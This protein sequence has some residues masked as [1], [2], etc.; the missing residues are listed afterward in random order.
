MRRSADAARQQARYDSRACFGCRMISPIGFKACLLADEISLYLAESP[1]PHHLK[2]RAV[3]PRPTP[4]WALRRAKRVAALRRFRRR[5]RRDGSRSIARRLIASSCYC[6]QHYYSDAVTRMPRRHYAQRRAARGGRVP[7]EFLCRRSITRVIR[8][9]ARRRACEFHAMASQLSRFDGMNSR[10]CH[11]RSAGRCLAPDCAMP[12]YCWIN[13]FNSHY[14]SRHFMMMASHF[15]RWRGC[16][17]WRNDATGGFA[18]SRQIS[19]A[20]LAE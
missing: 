5:G 17:L 11:G 15:D 4:P 14:A 8:L 6:R 13:G 7:V 2:C 9:I 1:S 10:A 18:I 20:R 12:R 19:N 16:R 3:S